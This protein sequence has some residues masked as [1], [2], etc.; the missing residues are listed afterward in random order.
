MNDRLKTILFLVFCLFGQWSFGQDT[1][2]RMAQI[3]ER[4]D[5]LVENGVELDKPVTIALTGDIQELIDFLAESTNLNISIDPAIK[6]K[7]SVTFTGVLIRD[8]VLYLCDNYELDL[9][10]TG[11]IV[12]FINY[13]PPPPLEKNRVLLIDYNEAS[14]LL[15]MNL[16][17]DTLESVMTKISEL[18]SQNIA[19]DP[20]VRYLKV[21]AYVNNLPL[22]PTLEQIATSN[23]LKLEKKDNFYTLSENDKLDDFG[24]AK[25]DNSAQN[26]AS[27]NASNGNNP[28]SNGNGNSLL[29][30]RIGPDLLNV[31]AENVPIVDVVKAAAEE[32][33]L[34]YV[35]LSDLNF[36]PQANANRNNQRNQSTSNRPQVTNNLISVRSKN[37]TFGALLSTI[38]KNSDFDFEKKGELYLIGKRQAEELRTYQLLQLQFRSARGVIDLVPEIMLK[39]IQVDTLFELNSIV[40]TGAKQNVKEVASFIRQLDKVV[41]VVTIELTIV[42]IQTDRIREMGVEAGVEQGGRPSGGT[43]IAPSDQGGINFTFSP[44]AINRVLD[45]LSGR[46]IVNLGQVNSNFY[47]SLSALQ[48]KGLIEI[49]STPQLSTLNSH[50]ATLSIGQ[51]RYFQEQQVNF[52]GVQQ[53]IPVQANIFR[54]VEAN[55]FININPIV[56]GDDEVTLDIFFEQSEFLEEPNVNAPPPQVSRKF[57]SMIR[58]R[59]GEMVV[60]GGLER[61]LNSQ[62][63]SG[64]PWI[65]Q[66]PVLGWLFGKKR[67]VRQNEKLLIFVKPTIVN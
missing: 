35:F 60:L 47:L 59:D 32:L 55:L 9:K 29:I 19:L 23:N 53:P 11:N 56:S 66:V 54:E 61:D 36:G 14:G 39:D 62:E 57:E 41:P 58:V 26:G 8:I 34:N 42:D 44:G 4:L 37:I 52:T 45:L 6:V 63:N 38:F 65:N 24:Q 50:D 51:K 13:V 10:P 18:T 21:N 5:I 22:E 48:R 7:V 3:Q 2:P 25:S 49:K 43:I 1:S 31:L 15:T 64:V 17:N 12:H 40:L 33:N 16:K 30:R 46:G 67:K 27:N 28:N 20:L